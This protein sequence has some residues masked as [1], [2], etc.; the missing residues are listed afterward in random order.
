MSDDNFKRPARLRAGS[1][2]ALVAP[3]GPVTEERIAASVARCESLGLAPIIGANAHLRESYLAGTDVER[4][5]DVMWAFTNPDID[6]VWALRGGYGTMRLHEHLDFDVMAQTRK[7]YLGF[8]DNTYV[9]LMLAAR[10]VVSFHA[11]HAGAEF[12]PE[13]EAA[14]LRVLFGDEAPGMLPT[15]PEDPAPRMLARGF[16]QGRLVGGN[17]S[18]LAATCGTPAQL[19]AHDGIVFIEEVGE[20]AYRVDR[21]L[22][23]LQ[24]AGALAGVRGFAFGRFSDIPEDSSESDIERLLID[25][26]RLYGVP[27]VMN[28]PIGHVEHNWTVPVGVRAVLDANACTLDLIEAAVS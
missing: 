14:L 6:A 7:P 25:L 13:T 23:Q 17:L 15:R 19:H 8:S 9:H 10:G 1:R 20:P 11:P 24:I 16:A 26:A 3:A 18:L 22:A 12:P 2:I 4:A 21:C 28:F 27:A 5:R